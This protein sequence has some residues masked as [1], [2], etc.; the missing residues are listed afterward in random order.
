METLLDDASDEEEED[1]EIV[2]GAFS[3]LG[4]GVSPIRSTP[5][6]RNPT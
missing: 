5:L 1:V 4:L 2:M 3:S 6:V